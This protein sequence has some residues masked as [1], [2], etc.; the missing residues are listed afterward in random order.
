[1]VFMY[2]IRGGQANLFVVVMLVGLV[3]V[4]GVSLAGYFSTYVASVSSESSLKNAIQY[5]IANTVVY[6][7]FDS[8]TAVWLG[9]IRID[10]SS[11]TYYMLVINTSSCVWQRI[12]EENIVS[13]LLSNGLEGVRAG[14][15][16]DLNS[17]YILDPDGNHIPIKTY[18]R[19]SSPITIYE[20]FV[21]AG[22][23]PK[24]IGPIPHGG[25]CVEVV[26]LTLANNNYYEV[27][28]V[29]V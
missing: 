8:G 25:G 18:Y 24:L 20:I 6:K 1:M 5:E 11:T 2:N 28:K 22:G 13:N 9:L 16:V 26:F 23:K 12:S 27:G 4:L 17:V 3:L 7:E 14:R 15:S 29:Y 21:E 10:G 19:G